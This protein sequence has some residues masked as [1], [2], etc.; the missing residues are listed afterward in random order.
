M[1]LQVLIKG[2]GG[3]VADIVGVLIIAAMLVF[4]W[5]LV[6]F[7][8]RVGGDEKA[9]EEGKN[10]MVWGLISLFVMVTVWGLVKFIGKEL[11]IGQGSSIPL[12]R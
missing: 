11:N 2:A 6:K 4:F 12:R 10:F 8:A 3:L 7:I 9:V 1:N 5:G